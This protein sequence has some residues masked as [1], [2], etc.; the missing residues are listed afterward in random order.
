MSLL[1]SLPEEVFALV[2]EALAM[3]G[4]NHALTTKLVCS[5]F[6]VPLLG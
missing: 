5:M 6:E 4:L 3:C 2:I 1:L